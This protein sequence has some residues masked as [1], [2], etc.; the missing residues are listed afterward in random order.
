MKVE[1]DSKKVRA[2]IS[3][4]FAGGRPDAFTL[5]FDFRRH[6]LKCVPNE[7]IGKD[8]YLAPMLALEHITYPKYLVG[9]EA[10]VVE[11]W[12]SQRYAWVQIA[13]D[14]EDN[15][16]GLEHWAQWMDRDHYE[17]GGTALAR[18]C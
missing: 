11:A 17:I 9:S 16:E 5:A 10:S 12:L 18:G 14:I 3:A 8:D 15:L 2:L 13:H 1:L 6:D 7:Q 4:Q